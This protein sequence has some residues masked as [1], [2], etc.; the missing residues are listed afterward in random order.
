MPSTKRT[1]SPAADDFVEAQPPLKKARTSPPESEVGEE[2]A[3][4]Q[5][6]PAPA[7]IP[8]TGT[9]RQSAPYSAPRTTSSTSRPSSVRPSTSSRLLAST[10]PQ[11]SSRP[12]RKE[13]S[14]G[15]EPSKSWRDYRTPAEAVKQADIQ[16]AAEQRRVAE[17]AAQAAEERQSKFRNRSTIRTITTKTLPD[18]TTEVTDTSRPAP[19]STFFAGY[20]KLGTEQPA[21]PKFDLAA[22][23]A[24][25]KAEES[26]QKQ[27]GTAQAATTSAASTA[28]K[29]RDAPA[30]GTRQNASPQK[31]STNATQ[32][33]P[34]TREPKAAASTAS[35]KRKAETDDTEEPPKKRSHDPSRIEAA[36]S[37]APPAVTTTTTKAK[38]RE[39]SKPS[40]QQTATPKPTTAHGSSAPEFKGNQ[41]DLGGDGGSRAKNPAITKPPKALPT[42]LPK[43]N[44]DA[45]AAIKKSLAAS[46]TKAV[47]KTD[48]LNTSDVSKKSALQKDDKQK[49]PEAGLAED[50]G[51]FAAGAT[52]SNKWR[53]FSEDIE[54]SDELEKRD[55]L[56]PNTTTIDKKS[57]NKEKSPKERESSE[58]SAIATSDD[59]IT[60]SEPPKR[61]S[62]SL[63]NSTSS[64]DSTRPREKGIAMKVEKRTAIKRKPRSQEEKAPAAHARKVKSFLKI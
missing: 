1:M 3:A 31:P 55:S 62:S 52:D 49:A 26:G 42:P 59:S 13:M 5:S 32:D 64:D 19:S 48:E 54:P 16:K 60:L 56:S 57:S 39:A 15:D 14:P 38:Q 8:Y 28:I 36:K 41:N 46:P 61:K 43:D 30:N 9:M 45:S 44:V 27:S 11:A 18:G 29:Q 37:R 4:K 17:A 63:S 25:E 12:T 51:V 10:S 24:R 34:A 21:E 47:A 2:T 35:A 40:Q 33:A 53:R 58:L 50:K 6:T 7:P 22:A 23:L 20:R